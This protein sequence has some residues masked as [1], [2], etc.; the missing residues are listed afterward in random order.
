[1]NGSGRKTAPEV[2]GSP[3]PTVTPGGRFSP[4]VLALTPAMRRPLSN[5]SLSGFYIL[6]I[7]RMHHKHGTHRHTDAFYAF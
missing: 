4:S 6:D 5:S 3:M 2:Y 7:T 1:M